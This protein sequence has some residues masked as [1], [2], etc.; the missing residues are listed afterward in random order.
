MIF[1]SS[2]ETVGEVS[3][4]TRLID[5]VERRLP[6]TEFEDPDAYVAFVLEEVLAFVEEDAEGEIET[7]DREEVETRLESLG[8]LE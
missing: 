5:R 4:P 6:R 8:Y 7:A 1:V 2:Q 3:I